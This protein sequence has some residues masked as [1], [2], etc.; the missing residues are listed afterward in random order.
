M[1]NNSNTSSTGAAG[2]PSTSMPFVDPKL[3]T[4]KAPWIQFLSALYNRT[5]GNQNQTTFSNLAISG[6]LTVQGSANIQ[7]SL[8][9]VGTLQGLGSYTTVV[10]KDPD[11]YISAS[12]QLQRSASGIPISLKL[13]WK[14]LAKDGVSSFF[15]SPIYVSNFTTSSYSG[16]ALVYQGFD[17]WIYA[18]NPLTGADITNWPYATSGVCYGRCQAQ[19][20]NGD[21]ITEVFGCSH[22]NQSGDTGAIYCIGGNGN[23]IWKV[24]NVYQAEGY[25][26]GMAN[27][28]TYNGNPYVTVGGVTATGG[29][30]SSAG[31]YSITVGGGATGWPTNAW[32]R[33]SGIGHNALV[34]ITAGT[35]AGQKNEISGVSGNVIYLNNA[36]GVVPDATSKFQI[37]PRYSSDVVFQHAG[38]LN[39]EGGTWYLYVT[40]DDNTLVKLN[41]TTG[42][43]V[44]RFWA[45]E[46][47][48]PYPLIADVRGSGSP[49]VMFNSIDMNCYNLS[50]GGTV[51]WQYTAPTGLDAFLDY[52]DVNGDGILEVL[53]NQRRSGNS[54]GGRTVVVR[55]TDGIPLYQST[56]FYGDLDSKP[57]PVPKTDGSGQ[58]NI[59]TVGDAGFCQFMD[60]TCFGLWQDNRGDTN[61]FNSFNCSPQLADVNYDGTKEIIA[62]N[63]QSAI[64]VYSQ[65]GARLATFALPS[66][67]GSTAVG[68]EG[69]PYIGDINGD[70]L[71]EFV[72]PSVDGYMYC[73]QF[74]K[75][76]G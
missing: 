45:G 51:N 3:G 57:L 39:N 34:A 13:L 64:M 23:L 29:P 59:F 42:I 76:A 25:N 75:N 32:Q 11:V 33:F 5:G 24:Y 35:G 18:V 65:Y 26:D 1:A 10:Q 48:E 20:V 7:G 16:A 36:W 74:Q 43:K 22:G 15:S 47:N 52:A 12:G 71:L 49:Q 55:G 69:I 14:R 4:I 21:G 56:D 31:T 19:D 6:T 41:A 54:A 37:I 17:W 38:T 30:I 27:S 68:I 40:G 61:A 53:V 58:Y 67:I 62:C 28:F 66:R 50:L 63:Q 73:Y 9:A 8:T 44:W 46:N 2:F 72:V 70:G 60:Y